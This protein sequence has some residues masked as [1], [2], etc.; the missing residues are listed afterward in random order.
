[1]EVNYLTDYDFWSD[2]LGNEDGKEDGSRTFKVGSLVCAFKAGDVSE[3]ST[4]ML[5]SSMDPEVDERHLILKI[6]CHIMHVLLQYLKRLKLKLEISNAELLQIESQVCRLCNLEV[7]DLSCGR[8][9][10][11]ADGT[12]TSPALCSILGSLPKL[13]SLD[14]S[15]NKLG[16]AL[17]TYLSSLCTPQLSSLVRS[18]MMSWRLQFFYI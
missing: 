10:T 18:V 11:S 7:L 2:V 13:R 16:G 17:N 1:M 4:A 12:K 14:L 9:T 6:L 8:L 5:L 3:P 15:N